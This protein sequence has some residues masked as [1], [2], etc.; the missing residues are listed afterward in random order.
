MEPKKGIKQKLHEKKVKLQEKVQD[1]KQRVQEKKVE[2]S[3]KMN[4]KREA[5]R[6]KIKEKKIIA[7]EQIHEKVQETKWFWQHNYFLILSL[8]PLLAI[9]IVSEISSIHRTAV[10]PNFFG[11]Q[12]TSLFDLWSIQ[13]FL[14]GVL[15]GSLLITPKYERTKKW[16]IM[17]PLTIFLAFAWEAVE[18]YLESGGIEAVQSF[19]NQREHWSNRLVS[20]PIMVIGG[21]VLGYIIHDSWK[22]AIIPS[23]IWLLIKAVLT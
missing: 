5:V 15:I 23:I 19:W 10:I 8:I 7:K 12:K 16:H 2:V 14:A 9:M 6:E 13:H 11:D 21:G 18:L 22:I 4:E 3:A 17:L 20:D 1:K